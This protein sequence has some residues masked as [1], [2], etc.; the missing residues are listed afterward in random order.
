MALVLSKKHSEAVGVI[1]RFLN[2]ENA[3]NWT[4][5]TLAALPVK[6]GFRLRGESMT[7]LEVFSD[8]AFAF[9]MTMLVVSV[10]SIPHSYSELILALKN[11]PAFALSFAQIAAFWVFH[12]NWSRQVGQE[13]K[14][15]TFLTLLMIFIILIYVYPLRL[16]FSSF[17]HFV[18]N[19]WLPSEFL[20]TN[21]R[22]MANLFIIYGVG[23]VGLT[24]VIGLLYLHAYRSAATL[25]LNTVETLLVRRSTLIWFAQVC[26]GFVSV[27]FAWLMPAYI[28]VYAGFVYFFLAIAIPLIYYITGPRI[29]AAQSELS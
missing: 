20:I 6:T 5:Q 8:A 12:R 1:Q 15:S 7:R 3:M 14:V 18:S 29:I 24:S 9:A 17:F 16:M 11:V 2:R 26:T 10:G 28:A 4:E 13:D 27:L 25:A 21:A 19:G 22:E 23:Y